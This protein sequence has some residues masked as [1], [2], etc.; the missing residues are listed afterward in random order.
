MSVAPSGIWAVSCGADRTLR[1]WERTDEPL[2]LGDID[3]NA[4]EELITG[5][6]VLTLYMIIIYGNSMNLTIVLYYNFSLTATFTR[7]T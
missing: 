2:V 7:S 6:K 5:E 4:E 1:L 3:E